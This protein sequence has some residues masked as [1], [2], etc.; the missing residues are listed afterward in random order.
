MKSNVFIFIVLSF[1]SVSCQEKKQM[2]ETDKETVENLYKDDKLN[3]LNHID[4]PIIEEQLSKQL[5]S[6]YLLKEEGLDGASEYNYTKK[7]Y[8]AINLISQEILKKNNYKFT[9]IS[10]KAL[11]IFNIKSNGDHKTIL[12]EGYCNPEPLYQLDF[13]GILSNNNPIQLDFKNNFLLESLFIP[14]LIDYQN[15]YPEIAKIESSIKTD[16]ESYKIILWKDARDLVQRRKLN[17]QIL[18]NRNL[19]LF[20]DDKS[21]LPWLLKK[22]QYFMKSLLLTFGWEGDDKLIN[23]VIKETPLKYNSKENNAEEF[24]KMLYNK[25][26]SGKLKIN[27][28]V[29]ELMAAND[30]QIHR[31][32]L[33]DYIHL[34][35]ANPDHK[36]DIKLTFPQI[37]EITA[38]AL[39]FIINNTQDE[40]EIYQYQGLFAETN[41]HDGKY[42]QEFTK[43]N[44]YGITGLKE[45]WEQ[46]KK[47][48][49]GIALPGEE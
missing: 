21:R 22:D 18:V 9:D 12:V 35:L 34:Y 6:G 27:R 10:D 2:V 5:K 32:N 11:S 40:Q 14:E 3:Y 23:W 24:G 39:N 42:S 16:F 25:D 36:S 31:K 15:Q 17:E 8:D 13:E 46:A 43:N 33:M 20:N 48:G 29:L 45:K 49:D 30:A 4:M 47:E 1:L 7:D 38:H 44:Y 19:Y 41:D 37:A 28:K 26:C